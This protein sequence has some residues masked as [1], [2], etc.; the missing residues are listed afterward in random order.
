MQSRICFN[1]LHNMVSGRP[2]LNWKDSLKIF[3]YRFLRQGFQLAQASLQLSVCQGWPWIS[4]PPASAFAITYWDWR[5]VPLPPPAGLEPRSSRMLGKHTTNW[6]TSLAL[7]ILILP[8]YSSSS[9]STIQQP[10]IFLCKTKMHRMGSFPIF[11]LFPQEKP[12]EP[13]PKHK[14]TLCFPT[15]GLIPI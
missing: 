1:T 13:I 14:I 3:W 7:K 11:E 6:A 9:R 2:C 10:F 4:N 5:H 12:A 8:N 15:N